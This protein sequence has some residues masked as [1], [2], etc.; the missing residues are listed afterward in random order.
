[1]LEEKTRI[2]KANN[3][4]KNR[5][6]RFLRISHPTTLN[7]IP[8]PHSKSKT[9][10]FHPIRKQQKPTLLPLNFLPKQLTKSV[11]PRRI[12]FIPTSLRRREG[13]ERIGLG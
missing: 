13:E 11:R 10:R 1:M 9:A 4:V 7:P 12:Y 6:N 8:K 2:K 3:K 5:K